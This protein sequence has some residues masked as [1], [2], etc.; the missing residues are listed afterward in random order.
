MHLSSLLR[1]EARTSIAHN[2]SGRRVRRGGHFFALNEIHFLRYSVPTGE[3]AEWSKAPV[4]KTG[5]LETVSRV[6]IPPSP[7]NYF[8]HAVKFFIETS[9][10]NDLSLLPEKYQEYPHLSSNSDPLRACV[11]SFRYAH[12]LWDDNSSFGFSFRH[13]GRN[14]SGQRATNVLPT[15]HP[16][17]SAWVARRTNRRR[18]N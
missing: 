5:R 6:R 3:V 15:P 7:P 9:D 16:H 17:S 13:L 2:H 10:L 14:R 18:S 12:Y 8:K 1:F 11:V 4:S